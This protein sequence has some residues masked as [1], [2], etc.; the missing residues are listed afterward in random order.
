MEARMQDVQ[1]EQAQAA[2]ARR[3]ELV[4]LVELVEGERNELRRIDLLEELAMSLR[5]EARL[6]VGLLDPAYRSLHVDECINI[7][8]AAGLG[9]LPELRDARIAAEVVYAEL[10]GGWEWEEAPEEDDD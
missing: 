5:S 9:V 8:E 3:E 2:A 4:E 7:S 6:S 10:M 1:V